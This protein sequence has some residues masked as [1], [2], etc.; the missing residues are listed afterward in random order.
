[1]NA[2]RELPT[3]IHWVVITPDVHAIEHKS[4]REI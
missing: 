3:K 2:A 1:M 4:E